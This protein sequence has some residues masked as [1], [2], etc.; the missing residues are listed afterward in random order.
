[1]SS[2]DYLSNIFVGGSLFDDNTSAPNQFYN[3]DDYKPTAGEYADKVLDAAKPVVKQ[4]DPVCPPGQVYNKAKQMCV[5][6]EESDGPPPVVVRPL[7]QHLLV[8]MKKETL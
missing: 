8:K 6:K 7:L 5:P 4:P 1:M 2:P 3:V